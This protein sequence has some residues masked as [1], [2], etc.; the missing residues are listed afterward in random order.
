MK[1]TYYWIKICYAGH[2]WLLVM[3][4]LFFWECWCQD[5]ASMTATTSSLVVNQTM[6][7]LLTLDN[8]DVSISMCRR[9]CTKDSF[10]AKLLVYL[11]NKIFLLLLRWKKLWDRRRCYCK[12]A[13]VVKRYQFFTRLTHHSLARG[14]KIMVTRLIS[15]FPRSFFFFQNF[16]DKLMSLVYVT[17]AGAG[18]RRGRDFVP[19]LVRDRQLLHHPWRVMIEGAD[20]NDVCPPPTNNAINKDQQHDK[21]NIAQV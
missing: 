5:Q 1:R 19:V 13:S 16:H 3:M 10:S 4:V 6:Q 12:G 14:S 8:V 9:C 21:H 18:D 2:R 7:L 20:D 15:Y 17:A 11:N